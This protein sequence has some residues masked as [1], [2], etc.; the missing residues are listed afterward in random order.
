VGS[1]EFEE[2]LVGVGALCGST[3]I[4]RSFH[5]WMVR[6]FGTYYTNVPSEKR[7]PS[8]H[9]FLRF[10][11]AKK[12]FTGPNSRRTIQVFPINMDISTDPS[13]DKENS[14]VLLKV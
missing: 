9:F 11:E 2:L 4:D 10:E 14:T 3:L 12:G 7:S 13:Y 5:D 8:S 1:I 6:K